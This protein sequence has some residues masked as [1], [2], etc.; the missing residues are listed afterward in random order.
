MIK[1][2]NIG[3]SNNSFFYNKPFYDKY[4][5]VYACVKN[6]GKVEGRSPLP[7]SSV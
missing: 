5:L 7:A 2:N 1:T 3:D 6:R 4:I